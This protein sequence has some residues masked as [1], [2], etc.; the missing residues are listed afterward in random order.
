MYVMEEKFC[1]K[2]K[3]G[4]V[5]FTICPLCL[6]SI[7]TEKSKL[8]SRSVNK[9]RC[10]YLPKALGKVAHRIEQSAIVVRDDFSFTL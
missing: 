5:P 8:P 2:M 9:G 4:F 1:F 6:M 3:G 7:Y 10:S